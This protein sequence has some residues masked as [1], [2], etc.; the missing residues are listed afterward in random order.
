MSLFSTKIPVNVKALIDQ[1]PKGAFIHR[2]EMTGIFDSNAQMLIRET[3]LEVVWSHEP[4]QTPL[5]VATD[6]PADLLQ[7]GKLPKGVSKSGG[8]KT[9]PKHQNAPTVKPE[10]KEVPTVTPPDYQWTEERLAAELAKGPVEFQGL[11]PV[12]TEVPKDHKHQDGFFYRKQEL[13]TTPVL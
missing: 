11:M 5:T 7:S 13:I 2:I 9:P 6:F 12:W 1:L 4:Y 3:E 8:K 10:A